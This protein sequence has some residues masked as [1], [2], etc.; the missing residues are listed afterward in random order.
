MDPKPRK[1]DKPSAQRLREAEKRLDEVMKRIAPF[2]PETRREDKPTA[3]QW[4][5]SRAGRAR[6]E[7]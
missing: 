5:Q 4:R 6:R 3:G 7:S 2:A 1:D